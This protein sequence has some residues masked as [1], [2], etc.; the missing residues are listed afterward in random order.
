[1]CSHLVKLFVVKGD[2][3]KKYEKVAYMIEEAIDPSQ[4]FKSASCSSAHSKLKASV[5]E[6]IMQLVL[7]GQVTG[8]QHN[9]SID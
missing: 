9:G 6:E 4:I 1:M 7:E 5:L 2:M 8:V 3:Q